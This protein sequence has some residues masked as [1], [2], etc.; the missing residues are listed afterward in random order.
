MYLYVFRSDEPWLVLSE[1][2]G[3][4]ACFE[5]LKEFNIEP[6]SKYLIPITFK[7]KVM[8]VAEVIFFLLSLI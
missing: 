5:T 1:M 8:G 3:T 2:T 7:P 4:S 6:N